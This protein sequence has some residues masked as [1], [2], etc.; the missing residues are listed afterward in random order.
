MDQK[1][2]NVL[3]REKFSPRTGSRLAKKAACSNVYGNEYQ[4]GHSANS[5]SCTRERFVQKG[6]GEKYFSAAKQGYNTSLML[7][8]LQIL[9]WGTST[10]P[11]CEYSRAFFSF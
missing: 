4:P 11:W 7:V 9:P 3:L 2:E 6:V 1:G 5:Y 8:K 10:C